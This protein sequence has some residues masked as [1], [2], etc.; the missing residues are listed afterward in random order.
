MKVLPTKLDGLLIVEPTVYR[1]ARGYFVETWRRSR[2]AACGPRDLVQDNL[3]WSSRGVLRGLHFQNPDPQ[4][5][6]VQVLEGEIFDVAVDVRR[7][8]PTFSKW[9]GV[10]LSSGNCRQI[11]VPEGFAHGFCVLSMSALVTYKCTAE[12]NPDAEMSVAWNDPQIAID[13][14]IDNPILSRKDAAAPTLESIPRNRLPRA[15]PKS[16]HVRPPSA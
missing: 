12:H 10:V 13:W 11:F 4:E 16:A 6:L 2:Y 14:P 7:G 9:C 1:D 8:S 3:S 5:K 15:E